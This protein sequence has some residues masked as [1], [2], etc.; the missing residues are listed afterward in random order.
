MKPA[1]TEEVFAYVKQCA[2]EMRTVTYKE[3]GEAVGLASA[4][5]GK[6]LG[7]IR[8]QVCLRWG[9][10]WLNVI[11]VNAASRRPGHSFLPGGVDFGPDDE[12]PWRA[13]VLA[14]FAYPWH[15][16]KSSSSMETLQTRTSDE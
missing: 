1:K 15:D 14:V 6:P 9:L 4:G 11:V 10:P 16:I 2:N 12:Q 3:V 13:M 5:V 8:D 7:Y